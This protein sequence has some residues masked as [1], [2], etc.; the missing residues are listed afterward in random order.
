MIEQNNL[1]LALTRF[2]GREK[3]I[4]EI[5]RLLS[6]PPQPSPA[7]GGG[8]DGTRLLTLTGAGGAGKTRLAIQVAQ[9]LTG[10]ANLSGLGFPDGVWLIELASL[11]DPALVP[12]TV[13]TIFDLRASGN[14]APMD[15][16]KNFLRDKNLLIV[17][18]NCEH[19]IDACAQLAESLLT[20]CPDVKILATSR[21]ALNIAGEIT[22][23][24]PSLALPDLRALP[25]LATFAQV[26]AIRLFSERA[27]ATQPGFELMQSNANAIAQICARLDGMPLAIELAAA[28]VKTLAIEQ[29]AAR[30]DDAFDLLTRGTRTAPT[31]QQTLRA[32]MDWSYDLLDEPERIL[33]RWLAVFTGGWTLDAAE[34]VVGQDA[35]LS[36]NVL[37]AF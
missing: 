10:L 18:D 6:P 11:A 3:E 37:D 32:T 31:R 28:R 20:H 24:V 19:L 4:T 15:L 34:A 33:F 2:I 9:D 36:H 26:E 14:L 7:R 8:S 23:R 16:L 17:L 1:P 22:F 30:L 12:Q 27:R 21:E 35:I 5:K 25:P 13:A 29:I